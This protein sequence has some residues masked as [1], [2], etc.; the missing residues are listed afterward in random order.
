V[1]ADF[2]VIFMD[3]QMPVMNGLDATRA[4]RVREGALGRHTPIVALTAHAIKG[5]REMCLEAGM[6]DYLSKPIQTSQLREVLAR[7]NT[8]AIAMAETGVETETEL[9]VARVP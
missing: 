8:P 9:E 6:D 5:D 4:I 2:D 7:W 1:H 3:V